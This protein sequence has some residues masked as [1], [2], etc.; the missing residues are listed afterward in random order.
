MSE[1][2]QDYLWTIAILGVC[3]LVVGLACEGAIPLWFA[4]MYVGLAAAPAR[5]FSR[6]WLR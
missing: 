1:T 2:S 3:G 5:V 4:F 6:G